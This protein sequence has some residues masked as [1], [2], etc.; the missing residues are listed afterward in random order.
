MLPAL[1]ALTGAGQ[2]PKEA[3]AEP[4]TDKVADKVAATVAS[5]GSDVVASTSY[6]VPSYLDPYVNM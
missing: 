4:A 2:L 3:S 5:K 6:K 1:G